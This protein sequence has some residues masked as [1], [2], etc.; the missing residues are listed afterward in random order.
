MNDCCTI[1]DEGTKM[2]LIMTA[3]NIWECKTCKI[4]Y[5]ENMGGLFIHVKGRYCCCGE[6]WAPRLIKGE[7]LLYPLYECPHCS[8]QFKIHEI[9][10]LITLTKT[11]VR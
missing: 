10:D 5:M 2:K 8:R 9:K 1:I 11:W 3:P 6:D 4:V 7:D